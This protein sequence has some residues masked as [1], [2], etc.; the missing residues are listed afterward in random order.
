VP[1]LII[2]SKTKLLLLCSASKIKQKV[3]IIGFFL[4]FYNFRYNLGVDFLIL[5]LT[6]H[7]IIEEFVGNPFG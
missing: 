5:N 4:D 3:A 6:M 2:S 7:Q 1:K